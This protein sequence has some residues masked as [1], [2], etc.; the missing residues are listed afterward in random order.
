MHVIAPEET[1]VRTIPSHKL[2]DTTIASDWR[3][4]ENKWR[5]RCR[6]VAR[7]FKS[8]NT[9]E[10]SFAPTTTFGAVRILLVLSM[11][12]NLM[13]TGIDVKDAFLCV[14]QQEEMFVVIPQWIRDLSPEDRF[15]VW[16]LKRCLPGQ[17]NAALRWFEYFSN[18]CQSAGMESYKGCPTIMKLVNSERR[19]YLSVHVDDVLLVGNEKDLEW[20]KKEVAS[21]LTIKVDGPH[22]QGSGDTMFYLKKR[23]TLLPE[24]I[25]VQPNGTYIP[26]LINMLKISGRR[27]KGLPHHVVL[28][29]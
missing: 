1:D 10:N 17:R 6:I 14:E 27:K 26:K 21:G 23:I 12:F 22:A 13:L 16:R 19:V 5:R 20:F 2:V 7:E 28:E 29:T 11:V 15:T 3:Y 8:D 9:D 24:G 18:L 25:L 4:R